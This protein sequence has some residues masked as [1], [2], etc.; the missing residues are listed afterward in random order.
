MRTFTTSRSAGL[1]LGIAAAVLLANPAVASATITGTG[2][3]TV[4]GTKFTTVIT[5]LK[6]DLPLLRCEGIAFDATKTDYNPA[7][8]ADPNVKLYEGAPAQVGSEYA[9]TGPTLVAGQVITNGSGTGTSADYPAGTY[10]VRTQCKEG[11]EAGAYQTPFTP[12]KLTIT[13]NSQNPNT[14]PGD[15]FKGLTTGSA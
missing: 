5:S 1:A 7:I 14:A 2:T 13:A 4:N 10:W 12:T 11:T 3:V 8:D 6:T 15:Q 9:I